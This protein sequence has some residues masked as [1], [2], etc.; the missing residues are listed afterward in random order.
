MK[1]GGAIFI[2]LAWVLAG[3]VHYQPQPLNPAQQAGDFE[4]RRLDS[5]D[6][7]S[8]VE[9]NL[10]HP[11][12]TWP[13][14]YWT[15]E[16][17]TLAAYYFHPSLDV[18]RAQWRVAEAAA[19]TAGA[20]PN[21]TVSLAPG[22]T[23]NS[24]ANISPWLMAV[25]FDWPVETAG[26]RSLRVAQAKHEVRIARFNLIT[27]AWQVR[28]KVRDSFATCRFAG[29]QCAMLE[30]KVRLQK[31]I[32][33]K[34]EERVNAGALSQTE[35]TPTRIILA[36]QEAALRLAQENEASAAAQLADA[37]SVPLSVIAS[38]P[39]TMT[40]YIPQ[41]SDAQLVEAKQRALL[42]RTDL[43]AA[44]AEYDAS[45]TLLQLEVAKQYPD[46]HFNPGYEF[47]QGDHKWRLG[48][49]FEL[50]VL[51][52]N[53]GPI[54]EA[55]ARRDEAAA[56]FLALQTKVI[57]EIDAA[58]QR[59]QRVRKQYFDLVPT[60]EAGAAQ[61]RTVEAKVHAGAADTLDL[62][63]A[64]LERLNDIGFWEETGHRSEVA[65]GQLEDALQQ[66]LERRAEVIA[67]A[68]PEHVETNPRENRAKP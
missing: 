18:A 36:Q 20:R 68:P 60:I 52:R 6:L 13:T 54:A 64:K 47:D 22:F 3:C 25:G 30:Q 46:I 37:I 23:A 7:R 21:P 49:S 11:I 34:L 9:A 40:L 48:L 67:P 58:T 10:G 2:A 41:L 17:F 32:V 61:E 56:R 28:A 31:D 65:L 39:K 53:Q 5:D 27:A 1:R 29:S 43:L 26:K 57:S 14:Q 12:T 16:Q 51:N 63:N 44:L 45:E 24:P 8:F 19:I 66:P 35:V 38:K 33:A 42:D 50:P 55:K 4:S 59:F 15:L 62:L